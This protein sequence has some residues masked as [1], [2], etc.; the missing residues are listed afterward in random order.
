MKL[1]I[2]DLGTNTFN[3][4]I[5]ESNIDQSFTKLFNTKVAVKLGEGSIN[6]SYIADVPFQ[7]GINTLKQFQQYLLDYNVVQTYAFATSAIRTASNGLEFTEQAEKIAG[8]TISIIDGDEEAELIYYG[9]KMAVN[10]SDKISLIMDIG[11]GSNEFILA[12]GN[13][14]FWKHSYLLGVARL[15]EKFKPSDPI[16][17]HEIECINLYLKAEMAILYTAVKEF[18]PIELIGSSG[19]FDSVIDIIAAEFGTESIN[20]KQTEYSVDLNQYKSIS[21]KVIA[22]TIKQRKHINGLIDMRI[23][24]IVLSFLL[25]D[26]VIS[27]FNITTIRVSTFSLKEGVINKKLGLKSK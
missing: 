22:S 17:K 27:E 2:I 11:G 18:P 5:V 12:N 25:I 23:D 13:T 16:T 14:I 20:D 7:R 15:L 6:K 4:L 24:M 1:A 21:K 10:M 8:I 26:F 19:A 9:N 3:L